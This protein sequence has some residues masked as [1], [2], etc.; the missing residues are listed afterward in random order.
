MIDHVIHK[1]GSG[2]TNK[3]R[4]S[5]TLAHHHLLCSVQQQP[6][7]AWCCQFFHHISSKLCMSHSP[8]SIVHSKYYPT[9]TWTLWRLPAQAFCC[10]H[11]YAQQLI[12]SWKA[13]NAAQ[14]SKTL[15]DIKNQPLTSHTIEIWVVLKKGSHFSACGIVR[16]GRS[17]L[18]HI[19]TGPWRTRKRWNCHTVWYQCE[20][21]CAD[22]KNLV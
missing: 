10:E 6:V 2:A 19:K 22:E 20:P 12:S 21:P 8:I 3:S 18:L 4:Q 5:L 17:L 15:M 1:K 16:S 14:I 13:G 9:P 11:L 7:F